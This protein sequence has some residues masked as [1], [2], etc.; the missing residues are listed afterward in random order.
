M[1]NKNFE[2]RFAVG[3]TPACTSS[4]FRIWGDD[5]LKDQNAKSDVYFAYRQIAGDLKISFH[6]SGQIN[7]SFTSQY[8]QKNE[9]EN[10]LRHIDTWTIDLTKPLFRILVPFTEI[11]RGLKDYHPQTQLIPAPPDGH[12]TDIFIHITDGYFTQLPDGY[13]VF[14]EKTL[15]SGNTLSIVWRIEPVT[16]HN[17]EIYTKAKAEAASFADPHRKE[18]SDMRSW[19]YLRNGD[20]RG[21]IDLSI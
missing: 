15:A 12:A 13:H 18:D 6:Q 19:L 21:F 16:E 7:H 17:R 8:A 11:I 20:D 5:P 14:F 4:V 9:I 1:G 3:D 2:L 10:H